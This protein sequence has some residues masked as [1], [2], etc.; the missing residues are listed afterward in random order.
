MKLPS[1]WCHGR[2]L[3]PCCVNWSSMKSW[4]W[5]IIIM[6]L[7]HNDTLFGNAYLYTRSA[8]REERFLTERLFYSVILNGPNRKRTTVR[9]TAH[10]SQS[11]YA[12][13]QDIVM[14]WFKN[15]AC[16][17]NENMGSST[18]LISFKS[19]SQNNSHWVKMKCRTQHKFGSGM[20][21]FTW[22]HYI[23]ADCN[24]CLG[25]YSLTKILG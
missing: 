21:K 23:K 10:G 7:R 14:V 2:T 19:N 15:G 3:N 5:R 13:F 8:C 6:A 4:V 20:S 22:Y 12:Y 17:F 16:V 9:T 11:S 18:I 24:I 25:Q 1:G